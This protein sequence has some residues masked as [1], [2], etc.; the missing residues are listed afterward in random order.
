V[1]G[2]NA[3]IMKRNCNSPGRNGKRIICDEKVLLFYI[4]KGNRDGEAHNN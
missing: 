3:Q 4:G 2:L 1:K